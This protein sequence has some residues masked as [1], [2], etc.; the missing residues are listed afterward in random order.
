[1]PEWK[2]PTDEPDVRDVSLVSDESE[3][4]QWLQTVA[5]AG[6]VRADPLE[7]PLRTRLD[8]ALRAVPGIE[9]VAEEDREVWVVED[10]NVFGEERIRASASMV[11]ALADEVRPSTRSESP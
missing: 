2:R 9:D 6:F 1:M 4:G 5:T 8:A 3:K 10:A 11:E 7:A